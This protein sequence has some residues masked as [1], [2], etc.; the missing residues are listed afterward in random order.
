MKYFALF[1]F[2][3]FSAL[4]ILPTVKVMKLHF[5]TSSKS[6]C[7]RSNSSE[8]T[9]GACQKEKCLLNFS[10]NNYTYVLFS[11]TFEL[12]NNVLFVP[13]AEKIAYQKNF[14]SN[15]NAT[16]WQPPESFFTV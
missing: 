8:E 14:I 6:S 11:N 5:A 16:I 9:N 13:K 7:H 1:V 10:I 4:T 2:F 15:Y 12:K 3:Y